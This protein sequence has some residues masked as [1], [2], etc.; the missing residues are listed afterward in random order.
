MRLVLDASVAVAAYRRD[1]PNHAAARARV[2][3][4]QMGR[5]TLIVP[6]IFVAEMTASMMRRGMGLA[7]VEHHVSR[8]FSRV[9][10][11]ATMGPKRGQKVADMAAR[12]RLRAA[13]AFYVWLAAERRATLITD[14]IEVIE[15]AAGV[16]KIAAP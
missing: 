11:C 1:E 7:F 12:T 6:S 9:D 10:E 4:I 3:R 14:D 15:R 8:L 2:Q 13:D 16:C 5:D